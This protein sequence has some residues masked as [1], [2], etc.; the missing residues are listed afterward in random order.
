MLGTS[1][2]NARMFRHVSDLFVVYSY[3]AVPEERSRYSAMVEVVKAKLGAV[4]APRKSRA[5]GTGTAS[6]SVDTT[7]ADAAVQSAMDMFT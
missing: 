4:G 5:K 2:P 7:A 1:S 6:S 3:L